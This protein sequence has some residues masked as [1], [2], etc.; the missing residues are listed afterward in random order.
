M[1]SRRLCRVKAL[2]F[3]IMTM[4]AMGPRSKYGQI[5]QKKKFIFYLQYKMRFSFLYCLQHAVHEEVNFRRMGNIYCLFS[6]RAFPY[7]LHRAILLLLATL[8]LEL[9]KEI[10]AREAFIKR[11]RVPPPRRVNIVLRACLFP[12]VA[13]AFLTT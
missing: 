7:P 6:L 1:K 5:F 11:R 12:V 13:S 2:L 9:N 8:R 3:F 4:K 10:L